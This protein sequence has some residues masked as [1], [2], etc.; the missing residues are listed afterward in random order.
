MTNVIRITG[1]LLALFAYQLIHAIDDLHL[2]GIMKDLDTQNKLENC[3]ITL[4][5]NGKK[6]SSIVTSADGKYEFHLE[7]NFQYEIKFSKELYVSKIIHFDLNNIPLKDQ[8]GGFMM[9]LSGTLFKN[10]KGFNRSILKKPIGK[11]YYSEDNGSMEWDENYFNEMKAQ[12]DAEFARLNSIQDKK[13]Y[14]EI[15]KAEKAMQPKK[16]KAAKKY[17]SK[18]LKIKPE[19]SLPKEKIKEIDRILEAN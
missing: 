3:E 18:A 19:E 12:I 11:I 15:S 17:Y 1:L 6:I 7:L 13:Y 2:R 4:Y 10:Q 9:D 8:E 5:R 16:W 14:S